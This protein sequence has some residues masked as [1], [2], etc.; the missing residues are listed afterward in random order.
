MPSS[1]KSPRKNLGMRPI[2]YGTDGDQNHVEIARGKV[3]AKQPSKK[4]PPRGYKKPQKQ[5]QALARKIS[6][7]P[8]V[9]S[10]VTMTK[11]DY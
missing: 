2:F 1:R 11:R 10:S 9:E 4:K 5:L 8:S 7:E 6:S 3:R